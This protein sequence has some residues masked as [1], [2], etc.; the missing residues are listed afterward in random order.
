ML[1]LRAHVKFLLYF[2]QFFFRFGGGG[3]DRSCRMLVG[4]CQLP[5]TRCSDSR[6]LLQAENGIRYVYICAV[7]MQA[8]SVIMSWKGLNFCVVITE[9]RY[10][11]GVKYSRV[12]YNERPYNERMLQRTVFVDK[13]RVLQRTR[14]KTIGRRSTRVRMA[15]RAFPLW[16]ERQAS[17]LLSFVRFSY[18]FN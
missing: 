6:T 11:R 1:T 13:I 17:S 2:P 16:L 10:N 18:Q 3:E 12:C 9:C 15:C 7:K 4:D 5:E 14:R 8:N